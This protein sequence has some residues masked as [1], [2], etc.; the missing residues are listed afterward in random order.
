MQIT[1]K[2][3]E[4]IKYLKKLSQKKYR[5][6]AGEFVVENV[7]II[8]DALKAG[9]VF[10]SVFVTESLLNGHDAKVR[11]ILERVREYFVIND[12]I[13]KVFSNL[14]TPS[15]IAV[16]YKI[17]SRELDFNDKIVYLNGISDP[18]N[19]GTMLR[20]AL[21]FGFKNIVLDETC[22]DLYNAKTIQ[23]TKDAVF[24][25]NIVVDKELLILQKIKKM[26]PVV[27]TRM[28]DAQDVRSFKAAKKY[29][30]VLGSEAHGVNAV[31]TELADAFIKIQMADTMESLNVAVASGILFFSLSA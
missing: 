11:A 18:G 30:L 2:D 15:G 26:M 16:V 19:L 6:E 14:D 13:N 10:D 29:C 27:V 23:A 17:K 4:K 8:Y 3:N 7:K 9:F 1:S 21:A 5:D 25:L 22:V 28:E 24:K 12:Q 20:S 31:I